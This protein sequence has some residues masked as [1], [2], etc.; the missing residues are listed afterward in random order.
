MLLLE[1]TPLLHMATQADAALAA[2]RIQLPPLLP[3]P[4]GR[5]RRGGRHE[6]Q[7]L[8]GGGNADQI[9]VQRPRLHPLSGPQFPHR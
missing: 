4:A 2:A 8:R 6:Y 1:E 9:R 7:A 3:P 5:V